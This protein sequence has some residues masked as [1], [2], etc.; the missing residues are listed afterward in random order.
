MPGKES[1]RERGRERRARGCRM[2]N[3]NVLLG[4]CGWVVV[5]RRG[6]RR[7]GSLPSSYIAPLF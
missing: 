5:E 1:E 2:Q 7:V 4:V 6:R 3:E